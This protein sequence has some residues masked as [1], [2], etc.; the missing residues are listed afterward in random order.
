MSHTSAQA[1]LEE[2]QRY[3]ATVTLSDNPAPLERYRGAV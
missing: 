3:D 1:L 2:L